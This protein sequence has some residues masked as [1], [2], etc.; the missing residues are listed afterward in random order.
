MAMSRGVGA[1]SSV[2][3]QCGVRRA[4][5]ASPASSER[6]ARTPH[7]VPSCNTA[8]HSGVSSGL[9]DEDG[10]RD[11]GSWPSWAA[12]PGLTLGCG[13][14]L[15]PAGLGSGGPARC[16]MLAASTE[17]WVSACAAHTGQAPAAGAGSTRPCPPRPRWHLGEAI[18]TA[19]SWH[20]FP[21]PSMLSSPPAPHNTSHPLPAWPGPHAP[22]VS[23]PGD[24]GRRDF[25][26]H[27]SSGGRSR[28]LA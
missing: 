27:L 13:C 10:D 17:V 4:P 3:L 26:R 19:G 11:R 2:S 18:K 7:N 25:A 21:L 8:R 6:M 5:V 12:R 22:H 1:A 14:V 23:L 28:L 16:S 15:G 20:T 9:R 24:A